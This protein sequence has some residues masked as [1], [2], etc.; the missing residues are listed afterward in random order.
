MSTVKKIDTI[1]SYFKIPPSILDQL[2][3][4]DVLLESDTLLFIDPMLLPE[5]KHSEMKD[6]ADQKYI[7]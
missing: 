4:V 7:D 6:D 3:V 2:D 1:S 5:S